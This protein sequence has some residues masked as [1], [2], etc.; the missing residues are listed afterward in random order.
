M[1][2]R[3]TQRTP[4]PLAQPSVALV[5]LVLELFFHRIDPRAKLLCCCIEAGNASSHR[6]PARLYA[7]R[8]GFRA[9][10]GAIHDGPPRHLDRV[11]QSSSRCQQ[12]HRLSSSLLMSAGRTLMHGVCA[13]KQ[14]KCTC[15]YYSN[16]IKYCIHDIE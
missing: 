8:H 2:R 10:L 5:D 6:F 4:P 15:V 11:P 14:P 12:A 16:A 3:E 7:T 1:A 9:I 13:G